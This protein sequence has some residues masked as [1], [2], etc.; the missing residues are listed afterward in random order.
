MQRP[1]EDHVSHHLKSEHISEE[2]RACIENCS[3]CHDTCVETLIHCLGIGGEHASLDHVRAL[4][5][6]SDACD[7]SRD[8][9][10]RGSALHARFC[11]ACAEACERCADSCERLGADDDVMR[12]CAETC[13]RCAEG[14]RAMSA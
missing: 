11:G 10:L 13:R 2:M 9:M 6:C 5:D 12:N 4:L 1:K 3:D 7:T 8:F 14:C